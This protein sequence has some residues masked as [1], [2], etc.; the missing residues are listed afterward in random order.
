MIKLNK[1]KS[2]HF[3]CETNPTMTTNKYNKTYSLGFYNKTYD[4]V[5]LAGVKFEAAIF[6][7]FL[8]SGIAV[9][10]VPDLSEA[11]NNNK[12]KGFQVGDVVRLKS[13]SVKMTVRGVDK[14]D[15]DYLNV[16]YFEGS[17]LIYAYLHKS[18]LVK[19]E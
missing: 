16:V 11:Q 12:P 1:T 7:N 5:S 4:Y 8:K 3:V 14:E 15:T 19:S 18:T 13:G 9:I 17:K 10:I 2:H 6:E